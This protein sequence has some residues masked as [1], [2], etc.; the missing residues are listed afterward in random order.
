MSLLYY[1]DAS[2][3]D[4][5][6][7]TT[8]AAVFVAEALESVTGKQMMIKWV[9]DIYSQDGKVSGILTESIKVGEKTAI[10]VGIG[11]NTGDVDFPDEL[12]GIA[13]T[14]GDVNGMENEI[15]AHIV[16]ELLRLS[17]D[18]VSREYMKGYRKRFMLRD[19]Y[20]TLFSC[21]EAIGE[22]RVLD[23]TD[24]GGLIF[25]RDGKTE[26]EVIHSGEITVRR[27]G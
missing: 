8:A 13:A 22:G 15:I 23:V 17:D 1:T 26:P 9:N 11:I 21:G 20:V 25:L 12:K 27:R 18:P 19:E 14:V 5:V 24:D 3:G 6:S 7:V 2:L 10:I 4:A 16:S